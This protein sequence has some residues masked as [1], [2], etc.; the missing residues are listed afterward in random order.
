M[1]GKVAQVKEAHRHR[2]AA[3]AHGPVF[4][5]YNEHDDWVKCEAGYTDGSSAVGRKI[6]VQD[7][8]NKVLLEGTV[9]QDNSFTFQPPVGA[10]SVGVAEPPSSLARIEVRSSV[11]RVACFLPSTPGHVP[12][13]F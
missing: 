3:S 7:T 9:D 5:C 8:S 10:Y 13:G 11:S 1:R 6:H 12:P 2:H 4:D